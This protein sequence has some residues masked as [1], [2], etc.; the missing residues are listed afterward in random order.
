MAPHTF[1]KLIYADD[2]VLTASQMQLKDKE[3]QRSTKKE[4]NKLLI[5]KLMDTS[6]SQAGK[7]SS[8]LK[9]SLKHHNKNSSEETD[10]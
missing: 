4:A 2:D 1:V 9:F 7:L 3:T 8:S 10:S 6:K 5:H